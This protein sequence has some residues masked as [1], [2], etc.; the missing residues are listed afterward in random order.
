MNTFCN[1]KDNIVYINC[2]I[3]KKDMINDELLV[4]ITKIL[5]LSLLNHDKFHIIADLKDIKMSVIDINF[6]KKLVHIFNT[7]F[8]NKL[9]V[10]KLL[11]YPE[12]FKNVYNIIKNM[13]DKDTRKK[14]IWIKKPLNNNYQENISLNCV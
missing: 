13:I 10:C 3:L 11:H 8:P 12:F 2:N 7:I 1:N 9:E 6:I 4:H 5:N 14:F